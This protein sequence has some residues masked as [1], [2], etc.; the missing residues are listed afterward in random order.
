MRTEREITEIYERNVGTVWRVCF[1][2]MKNA[3]DTEDAVQETFFRLISKAPRFENAEHE[4]AWLIRTASNICK[5]EL[6]NPRRRHEDID[7]HTELQGGEP[8]QTD[9]V[10]R[11]VMEL[12]DKYKTVIYLYYYEGCDSVKIAEMLGKPR[13]TVRNHLHEAREL[14][15]ER[16][17]EF[18]EK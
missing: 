10:L 18:Y 15:R 1:A 16:L 6:K 3:A 12:P 2:Y 13:S 9:E 14:L 5:N 8:P 7:D 17:G 11:A 4:K